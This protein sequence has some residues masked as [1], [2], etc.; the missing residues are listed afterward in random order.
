MTELFLS[1]VIICV[2]RDNVLLSMRRTWNYIRSEKSDLWNCIYASYGGPDFDQSDMDAMI[3]C[4]TSVFASQS[5]GVRN[6]QTWPIDQVDWPTDN[7]QRQDIFLD[8]TL[9]R[10]YIAYAEAVRIMPALP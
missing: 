1:L 2:Q 7:S 6:L 4:V 10:D 5:R 3:W 9:N 8:P